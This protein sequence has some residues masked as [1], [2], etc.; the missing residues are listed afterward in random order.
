MPPKFKD[1]DVLVSISGKYVSWAHTIAAYS[2]IL[3]PPIELL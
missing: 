3:S 2:M 1:G